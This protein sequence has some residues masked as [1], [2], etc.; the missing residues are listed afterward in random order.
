LENNEYMLPCL[1]AVAAQQTSFLRPNLLLTVV[2]KIRERD[3][4]AEMPICMVKL[5][6]YIKRQQ[7]RAE[8]TAAAAAAGEGD[9]A[10]KQEQ[11]QGR[12]QQQQQQQRVAAAGGSDGRPKAVTCSGIVYCLSRKE[13][14]QVAGMLKEVGGIRAK[15]YHAGMTPKQRTEV[16]GCG[17]CWLG[18]DV[19][20]GGVQI[21]LL[22]GGDTS[23]GLTPGCSSQQCFYRFDKCSNHCM[24]T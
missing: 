10:V 11:Q 19:L 22:L 12:Q 23:A 2:P 15:H 16:R 4:E 21:N 20:S 3:E 9:P 18:T 1:P 17:H 5:I 24:Y 7:A 13:A 6:E 14:E 8:A